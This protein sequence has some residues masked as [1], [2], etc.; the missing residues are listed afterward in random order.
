[1]IF[2]V[3]LRLPA[4]VFPIPPLMIGAP[5]TFSFGIQVS[6]PVVGGAAVVSMIVDR[7][8]QFRFRFLDGVLALASVVCVHKRRRHK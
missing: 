1:M 4:V 6:P 7:T 8:V 5:A 3:M 2:P